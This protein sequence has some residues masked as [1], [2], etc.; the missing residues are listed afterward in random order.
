MKIKKEKCRECGMEVQS[1]NI[2]NHAKNHEFEKKA[3]L[4]AAAKK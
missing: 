2:T 4:A 1:F 3:A